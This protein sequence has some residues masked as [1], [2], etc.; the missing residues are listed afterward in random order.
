MSNYKSLDD[1]PAVNTVRVQS[2]IIYNAP[3]S[4]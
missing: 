3:C 1:I 4:Y 2:Y